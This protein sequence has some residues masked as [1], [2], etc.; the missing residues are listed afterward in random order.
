[1]VKEIPYIKKDAGIYN[2]SCE[3]YLYEPLVPTGRWSLVTDQYRTNALYIEH[4]RWLFFTTWINE[5]EIEFLPEEKEVIFNCNKR[6][7]T[8]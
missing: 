5:R 2:A 8:Q 4:R 3:F 1:M 6:S 7:N